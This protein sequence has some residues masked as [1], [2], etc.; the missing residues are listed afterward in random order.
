[1]E[2]ILS[3]EILDWVVSLCPRGAL[4]ALSLTSKKLNRIAVPHLYSE[5]VFDQK[6]EWED[7][8]V[9]LLPFTH[10]IFSSQSHA[11]LV[12]SL[13]LPEPVGWEQEELDKGEA[14]ELAAKPWPGAGSEELE[15]L[16]RKKCGE[17]ALDEK[18][19]NELYEK[20]ASGLNADAIFALLLFNLPNLQKL[21]LN[22]GMCKNRPAMIAMLERVGQ[23]VKPFDKIPS[24]LDD[25]EAIEKFASTST[26]GLS[27]PLDVMVKFNTDKY[28]EDP[29]HIGAF[30]N[31]PFLRSIH[32]FMTGDDTNTSSDNPIGKLKP[33][34]CGVE[35]IELRRTKIHN[36]NLKCLLDATI[37]GKL[38]TFYYEIGNT[39]AWCA[40]E[41]P[42][43]MKTLEAHHDT[44]ENLGMS[45]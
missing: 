10:L 16:L 6:K 19:T 13:V 8:L 5:A 35:Y 37:P 24:D 23:R 27:K 42:T 43:I 25:E 36:D 44:L 12:K 17:Y 1:M 38:K 20:I 9:Y 29:R 22:V 28:P 32:T 14:A 18:D 21:D 30:F 45:Q 2:D 4:A 39:W 40:V 15:K 33:R 31:L 11:S 41:H 7:P 26:V 3:E 34:S